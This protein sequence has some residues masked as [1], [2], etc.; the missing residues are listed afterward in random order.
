MWNVMSYTT[1]KAI[2]RNPPEVGK[3]PINLVSLNNK[4]L[5]VHVG[6][7]KLNIAR[8]GSLRGTFVE[9]RRVLHAA[10]LRLSL[11][12]TPEELVRWWLPPIC[13]T[14]L[15]RTTLDL[16]TQTPQNNQVWTNKIFRPE[17]HCN[18]PL[19]KQQCMKKT[20]KSNKTKKKK[21]E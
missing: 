10:N 3:C 18:S 14:L 7:S 11:A 9:F 20:S 8:F 6:F 12:S 13:V 4:G 5:Q 16:H 1:G 15:T 17:S 19:K 21:K 2:T